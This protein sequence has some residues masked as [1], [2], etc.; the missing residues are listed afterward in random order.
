[1]SDDGDPL[2]IRSLEF[3]ANLHEI[4]LYLLNM[5]IQI[6]LVLLKVLDFQLCFVDLI[7]QLSILAL[8]LVAFGVVHGRFCSG[9]AADARCR[10]IAI[11]NLRG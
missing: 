2:V 5:R 7:P 10:S 8:E 1:L 3:L 4:F 9:P 6:C 11:P